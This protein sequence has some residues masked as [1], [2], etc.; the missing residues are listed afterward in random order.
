MTYGSVK[1]RFLS[2]AESC[3][4]F[5]INVLSFPFRFVMRAVVNGKAYAEGSGKKKMEAKQKA[6][7]NAFKSLLGESVDSVRISFIVDVLHV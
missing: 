1:C 6:A 7:E 5:S 3:N 4:S 2:P